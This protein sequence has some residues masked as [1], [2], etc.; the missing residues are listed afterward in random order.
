MSQQFLFQQRVGIL[1]T[2]HQKE[3]AIAP[4]LE[5]ALGLTI[6][7]PPNFDTDLFGTFTRDIKRP[8]NQLETAKLKAQKALEL[9]QETLAFASEGAFIPH[10]NFPWVMCDR[11]I[12]LL[13]DTQH[14]LQIIGEELSTETNFNHQSVTHLEAAKTFAQKVQFPSHGLILRASLDRAEPGTIF[15]GITSEAQLETA[16]REAQKHSSDGKIHLETDMRALY[17]PTRMK[18]IAKATQ[19]LI[20]KINSTCPQCSTPGFDIVEQHKGLRC[21]ACN[22]PTALIKAVTYQCSHCGFRQEQL[23]PNN[24]QKADP[25]YCAYCNP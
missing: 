21:A 19:N 7:V 23:Y 5:P 2:K 1:A 4:L 25:T 10:P 15:K 3:K 18:A 6:K 11:E 8:A 24:L 20:Q 12:V 17:N 16:F 9:T 22:F 13:Y 14:N